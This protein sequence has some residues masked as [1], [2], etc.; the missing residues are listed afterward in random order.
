MLFFEYVFSARF[1]QR[2][3][4]YTF[5]LSLDEPPDKSYS[6]TAKVL[7]MIHDVSAEYGPHPALVFAAILTMYGTPA[8]SCFNVVE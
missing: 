2:D 7:E 5:K 4:A 6:R 8:T 3:S 1:C